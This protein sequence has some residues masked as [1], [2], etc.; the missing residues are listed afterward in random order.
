MCAGTARIELRAGALLVTF[1]ARNGRATVTREAIVR[2]VALVGR[3]GDR[4]RAETIRA[5]FIGRSK[6]QSIREGLRALSDY[7]S[8][9]A[10]AAAMIGLSCAQLPDELPPAPHRT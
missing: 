6:H 3:R 7:V 4:F 9:N 10:P 8:D 5:E 2:D 1:D